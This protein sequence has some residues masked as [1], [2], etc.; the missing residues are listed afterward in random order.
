MNAYLGKVGKIDFFLD[1]FSVKSNQ[2]LTFTD[3][4]KV[5][6]LTTVAGYLK[7]DEISINGFINYN[8][9]SLNDFLSFLLNDKRAAPRKFDLNFSFSQKSSQN[10]LLAYKGQGE[11]HEEECL[12]SFSA[13]VDST[14]TLMAALDKNLKVKPMWIDFGQKNAMAEKKK[15]IEIC[16]K[17]RLKPI[18][19]NI[20]LAKFVEEG[21]GEWKYGI[22]PARNFL[23][24]SFAASYLLNSKAKVKRIWLGAHKGEIS[25]TNTDKSIRFFKTS[26]K[27]FSQ[28]FNQKFIVE[29][30]FF[31]YSEVEVLSHW[32][33]HWL[34]KYKLHP[35]ETTSCYLGNNCGTCK[36]C[37]NRNM[38]F[39]IAGLEPEKFIVNPM[40]DKTRM[41]RNGYIKRFDTLLPERKVDFLISFKKAH[42]AL[43]ESIKKFYQK[44]SKKYQKAMAQREKEIKE[45][46]VK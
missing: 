42:S 21:W 14:A 35:S 41:I 34:E 45:V 7:K 22:I 39:L 37:V 19:L 2:S 23:F 33:K 32:Q 44:K 16:R 17:F 24:I 36:A 4:N 25:A 9:A 20:D 43:P 18:I 5:A 30:P 26:S 12:V 28:I 46:V 27:M 8:L 10:I 13:G 40:A 38:N 6:L 11:K 3:L 15:V 29:T 1:S 31:Q